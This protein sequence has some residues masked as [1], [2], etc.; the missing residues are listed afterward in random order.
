MKDWDMYKIMAFAIGSFD[1][2]NSYTI[3]FKGW[4][5]KYPINLG[6]ILVHINKG[7]GGETF[8]EYEVIKITAYPGDQCRRDVAYPG[9]SCELIVKGNRV[10]Q[11]DFVDLRENGGLYFIKN[12]D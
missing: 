2:I 11:H 1:T 4:V 6:D 12:V 3:S 5:G 9:M 7:D 8:T 10:E